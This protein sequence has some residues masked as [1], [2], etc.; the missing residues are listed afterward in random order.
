MKIILD[1]HVT[2]PDDWRYR[3]S[4]HEER[5]VH[6][7]YTPSP[8][9]LPDRVTFPDGGNVAGS[10]KIN[11]DQRFLLHSRFFRFVALLGR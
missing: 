2:R 5:G 6:S 9:F 8:E 3:A 7:A 11:Q 4:G 1:G 10:R